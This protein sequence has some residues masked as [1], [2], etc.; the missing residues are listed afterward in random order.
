MYR[1]VVSAT[2][3]DPAERAACIPPARRA[4]RSAAAGWG[5]GDGVL[6]DLAVVVGELLSNACRHAGPA[7]VRVLLSLA[8][9]GGRVR[10]D[11]EDQ[12]VALPSVGP[13][14]FGDGQAEG[15]RGLLMV[16]ALSERWGSTST[17]TG[18]VVWAELVLPV[19]LDVPGITGRARQ[20]QARADYMRA[21]AVGA[22]PVRMPA[23]RLRP[24]VPGAERP[25]PRTAGKPG[26]PLPT[27][28][29]RRRRP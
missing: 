11:V 7:R 4:I 20:A 8:S 24:L 18:K 17:G 21:A 16:R 22:D 25:G 15:G 6:D 29:R 13:D 9:D 2:D 5:V 19:P 28:P 12:G 27:A 3:P 10:V 1:L 23:C 14:G 26:G